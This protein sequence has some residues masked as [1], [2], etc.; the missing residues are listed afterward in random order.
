[1]FPFKV[2]TWEI[3]FFGGVFLTAY[4]T[5]RDFLFPENTH[6]TDT[7]DEIYIHEMFARSLLVVSV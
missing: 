7:K 2:V 3:L 6:W 4:A 5:L 1:M